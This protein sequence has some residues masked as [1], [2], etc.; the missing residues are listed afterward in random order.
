MPP[1]LYEP[2]RRL[3]RRGKVA[4]FAVGQEVVDRGGRRALFLK[5]RAE[6]PRA[7][8]FGDDILRGLPRG[9]VQAF[10][11]LFMSERPFYVDETLAAAEVSVRLLAGDAM[12]PEKSKG[13]TRLRFSVEAHVWPTVLMLQML[14][15]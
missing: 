13:H 11:D 9:K 5:L 10:A 14:N 6:L 4:R 1:R 3:E 7:V 2:A 15:D 8:P 12:T